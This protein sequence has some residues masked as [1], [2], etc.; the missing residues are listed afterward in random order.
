MG[1]PKDGREE[2]MF[3]VLTARQQMTFIALISAFQELR[4]DLS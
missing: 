1:Y 4:E 3:L 2:I